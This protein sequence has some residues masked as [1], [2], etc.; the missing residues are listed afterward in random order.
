MSSQDRKNLRF[1]SQGAPKDHRNSN[2]PA[3]RCPAPC[4][5]PRRCPTQRERT[6]AQSR[7][8]QATGF[9]DGPIPPILTARGRH[10]RLLAIWRP[11][12]W[13]PR[14]SPIDIPALASERSARGG[15]TRNLPL[16]DAQA[17][18]R[19]VRSAVALTE[20]VAHDCLFI[21]RAG[22][23]PCLIADSAAGEYPRSR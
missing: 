6:W 1:P 10:R 22:A 8:W 5:S 2:S 3:V 7:L 16:D 4:P 21:G 23:C 15:S 11:P 12:R 18:A 13:R 14:S 20:I 17:S 19:T 9:S